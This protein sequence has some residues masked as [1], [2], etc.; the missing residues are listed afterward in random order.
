MKNEFGELT[1][2]LSI[3]TPKAGLAEI[4]CW[5]CQARRAAVNLT[6]IHS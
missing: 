1:L 4:F 3:A 6:A 5:P 2:D